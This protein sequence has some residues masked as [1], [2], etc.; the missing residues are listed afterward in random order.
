MR[1]PDL[2]T[3][4]RIAGMNHRTSHLRSAG[5][6]LRSLR[7][8]P[9]VDQRGFLCPF[10]RAGV[11]SL[12]R[13][14][15]RKDWWE[16]FL[17]E[18]VVS[19]SLRLIGKNILSFGGPFQTNFCLEKCNLVGKS[20]MCRPTK[21]KKSLMPKKRQNVFHFVDKQPFYGHDG[22]LIMQ[23]LKVRGGFIDHE[24]FLIAVGATKRN[25]KPRPK[26]HKKLPFWS[27]ASILGH[28]GHLQ[29]S[30]VLE[31]WTNYYP[32]WNMWTKK[33]TDAKPCKNVTCS[34]AC[35]RTITI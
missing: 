24:I 13:Q 23:F 31:I 29:V 9:G 3:P 6:M 10:I 35:E 20:I 26:T 8:L 11:F 32:I 30:L 21:K 12:G 4:T 25:N 22:T 1:W 7:R 28:I 18:S 14:I 27:K 5:R 17:L 2:W 34:V 33:L 16:Q 15:S 19:L